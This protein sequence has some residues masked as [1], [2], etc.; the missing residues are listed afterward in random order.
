M[1]LLDFK[2][3]TIPTS[4]GV[5]FFEDANGHVLYVGKATS[6]R[7]RIRSYFA[8]D[9]IKTRGPHIV[10]MVFKATS[11]SWEECT[12]VLEALILEA[13]EIKKRKPYYNTKEKDDK[14]FNCVVITKEEFPRVLLVRQRDVVYKKTKPEIAKIKNEIIFID[15]MY[16]PFPSATLI[17]EGLRIVRRIFPFRDRVSIQKDKEVFY[18][19]LG[20]TPDITTANARKQYKETIHQIH[21]CVLC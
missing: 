17:K 11:V 2:K 6:L 20:L 10:D 5:Y 3:L 13:S 1:T 15:S 4:P 18:R 8:S 9:V 14:S 16:G 12:N 19:Q 21:R 7:D